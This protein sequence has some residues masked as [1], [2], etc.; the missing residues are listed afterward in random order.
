MESI[1]GANGCAHCG[2][3]LAIP[4]DHAQQGHQPITDLGHMLTRLTRMRGSQV[5]AEEKRLRISPTVW[6]HTGLWSNG[7][8]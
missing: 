7:A 2:N 4:T 1:V 3:A 6:D 8:M 5:S